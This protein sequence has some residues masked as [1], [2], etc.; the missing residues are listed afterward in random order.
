[1]A[2]ARLGHADLLLRAHDAA[3]RALDLMDSRRLYRG[4]PALRFYGGDVSRK[5]RRKSAPLLLLARSGSI[6]FWKS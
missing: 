2:T 6:L 1:M 4:G 3:W 5:K